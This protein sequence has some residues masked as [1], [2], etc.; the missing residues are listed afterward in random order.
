MKEDTRIRLLTDKQLDYVAG[1]YW[2]YTNFGN[3]LVLMA[4]FKDTE[5]AKKAFRIMENH[6]LER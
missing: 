5:E 6:S 4:E 3:N 2:Q 1:L